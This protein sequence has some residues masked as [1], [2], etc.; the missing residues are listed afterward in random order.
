MFLTPSSTPCWTIERSPKNKKRAPRCMGTLRQKTERAP[1]CMGTLFVFSWSSWVPPRAPLAIAPNIHF[2]TIFCIFCSS[3]STWWPLRAWSRREGGGR[4]RTHAR[5][6]GRTNAGGS[7]DVGKVTGAPKAWFF[8][9]SF[10]FRCRFANFAL[11]DPL[12]GRSRRALH[13]ENMHYRIGFIDVF[14][15]LI[16]SMLD[17]RTVTKK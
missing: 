5:T 8:N 2:Q 6:D 3:G 10:I 1:R 9:N 11:R 13:F 17:H 15:A 7:W 4:G 12:G 16:D 14:D